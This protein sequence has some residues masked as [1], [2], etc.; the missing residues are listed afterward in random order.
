MEEHSTKP[1]NTD[2]IPTED[3]KVTEITKDDEV[4]QYSLA[5]GAEY[6]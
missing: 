2:I 6:E 4:S 1:N 3:H 5:S